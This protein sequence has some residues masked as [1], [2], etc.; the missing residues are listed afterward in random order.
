MPKKANELPLIEPV[1][2]DDDLCSGL[3]QIEDVGLGARFVFFARQMSYEAESQVLV[4][5]RKIVLPLDVIIPSLE[6]AIAFLANCEEDR[7]RKMARL[8]L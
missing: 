5:K 7:W 6:T 4:V 3:A 2:I 1:P 8:R